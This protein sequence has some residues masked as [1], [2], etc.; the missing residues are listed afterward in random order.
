MLVTSRKGYNLVSVVG[1]QNFREDGGL[2][3]M[4]V[5]K[6]VLKDTLLGLI[7]WFKIKLSK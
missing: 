6:Y 7:E 2:C 1:R 3:D 4:W 5:R